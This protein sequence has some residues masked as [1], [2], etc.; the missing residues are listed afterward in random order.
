MNRNMRNNFFKFSSFLFSAF[1]ITSA[2][3]SDEIKFSGEV[4]QG[5]NYEKEIGDNL[6]FR[7]IPDGLGW[8]IFLGSKT[9]QA[10]LKDSGSS[11]KDIS[12]TSMGP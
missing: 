10:L 1:F 2:L 8:T 9:S 12:S 11:R 3:F 6:F 5:Q 7:L 4:R